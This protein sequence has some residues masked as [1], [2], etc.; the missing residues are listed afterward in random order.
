MSPKGATHEDVHCSNIYRDNLVGPPQESGQGKTR[1][2]HTR[3]HG[4]VGS[5]SRNK[6]AGLKGGLLCNKSEHQNTIYSTY[7]LHKLNLYAVRQNTHFARTYASN[8]FTGSTLEWL[9]KGRV[10][11]KG[12]E[13]KGKGEKPMKEKEETH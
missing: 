1:R 9:P 2:E 8:T 10:M 7:H 12:S 11:G 4:A 6:L 5:I 3:E 13:K